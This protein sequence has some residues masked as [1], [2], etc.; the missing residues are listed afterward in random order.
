MQDLHIGRGVTRGAMTVFPI[1]SATYGH[2]N[3]SLT[4]RHLHVAEVDTSPQVGTLVL[5]NEGDKPAL[6]FEGQLFEGGWQ[7]RMATRSILVGVHQRVPLDVACV[8]QGRWSG[9]RRQMT[10]GRRA[11][12]YVR[13]AVRRGGDVQGEVW[14]RIARH[15]IGRGNETQSFVRHLDEVGAEVP[16]W[17]DLLPLPGQCGVLIGVG[18]QPYVAEVF[19]NSSVL[20]RQLSSILASA[21]L[22]AIGAPGGATPGRRARRFLDRVSLIRMQRAGVAG[23]GE[24]HAGRSQYANVTSLLW[25]GRQLHT[26]LANVRHPLLA[27]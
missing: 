25:D 22:D 3:Y 27:A 15:T 16:D 8:E 13:D 12:P 4:G 1:W 5:D 26:R 23:L 19:E 11:T 6:V 10:R 2:G 7:H 21:S 17:S 20:R 9:G 18:G 24:E 14:S